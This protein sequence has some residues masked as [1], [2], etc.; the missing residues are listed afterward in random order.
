[1]GIAVSYRYMDVWRRVAERKIQ[2]AMTEGAFDCLSGEGQPLRLDE[3]PFEDPSLRMAHR[4]LRNNGFAPA[5]IEEAKDLDAEMDTVRT[6][7]RSAG[8]NASL[9]RWRERAQ[10]LN[11]RIVVFNLKTPSA[12]WHRL[13]VDPDLEIARR[14]AR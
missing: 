12:V 2:E 11:Q 3:D 13:P 7:L 10:R 6:G 4:L 5:W 9:T 14:S 8:D 1:M